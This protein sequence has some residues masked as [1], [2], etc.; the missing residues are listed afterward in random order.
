MRWIVVVCLIAG[1]LAVAPVRALAAP[2][3]E[4]VRDFLL[5]IGGDAT[6]RQGETAG[7]V[8]L[9]VLKLGSI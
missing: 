5:R 9:P 8:V 6:V 3:D 1:L 4:D 2:N 7:A